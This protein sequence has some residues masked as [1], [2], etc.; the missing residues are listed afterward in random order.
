MSWYCII[1]FCGLGTVPVVCKRLQRNFIG[2]EINPE[3][4]D[5]SEKRCKIGKYKEEQQTKS[6]SLF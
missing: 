5:L 6:N 2:F 4:I 1:P 3:F